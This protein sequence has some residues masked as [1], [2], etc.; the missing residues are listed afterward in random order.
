[1]KIIV[2]I[3]GASGAI[4][5]VRLLEYLKKNNIESHLIVSRMAERTIETELEID[6]SRVKLMGT[7][8]YEPE[9]VDAKI[10]S[11]SFKHD[12]M[13]IIPCSMKT[14]A[15]IASGYTS[16]LI[17]RAADVTL[18]EKRKLVIAPRETPLNVIHLQNMLK[19][20]EAG[21]VILPPMPAFY[22]KPKGI[23]D[24]VNYVVGKALDA[25][26]IPH[27]LFSRWGD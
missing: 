26:D 22:T 24:V 5:G 27:D 10:S 18:K 17:S 3:T 1:M 6:V 14:M 2:G 8:C 23:D 4:L 11:G 20:A 21:V 15:A 9:R 25:L 7:C 19:L 12:G 16:E 13:I